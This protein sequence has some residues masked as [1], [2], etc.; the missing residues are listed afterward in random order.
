MKNIK[1]AIIIIITFCFQ[2]FSQTKEWATY[3][4]DSIVSVDMPF[5]VY[6]TDTIQNNRK[7]LQIFSSNDTISF[8]AQKLYLG[9]LYANVETEPLPHDDKSL[10]KRYND[11]I[12]FFIE[13]YPFDLK[14]TKE[15]KYQ[16]LKG[17]KLLFNNKKEIPVQEMNL[18][19]VNKNL[20]NFSYQ[21]INGLNK[22]DK[23]KFFDSITFNNEKELYQFAKTSYSY[24]K[25]FLIALL[26]IF[27]LSFFLGFKKKKT[28]LQ[29]E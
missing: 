6:E 18:I 8:I 4:F 12:S 19:I 21:N 27:F 23:K 26:V 16:N 28:K 20:Y 22:S 15:I 9:K 14:S 13:G 25:I 10:E 2:S 7:L 1:I 11:I 24:F 29:I 5:D 17:Y 3:D